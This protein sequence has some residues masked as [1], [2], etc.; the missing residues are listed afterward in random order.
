PPAEIQIELFLFFEVGGFANLS[1]MMDDERA[2][3]R[4]Q[5]QLCDDGLNQFVN[6]AHKANARIVAKQPEHKYFN[7]ITELAPFVIVFGVWNRTDVVGIPQVSALNQSDGR[8]LGDFC[9][10]PDQTDISFCK[11]F[12]RIE[13][14]NPV[15]AGLVY[16]MILGCAEVSGPGEV[17]HASS[18]A[19]GNLNSA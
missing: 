5:F 6:P 13:K 17:E 2:F 11:A 1:E 14:E 8:G 15:A 4:V 10:F 16:R 7:A 9:F 3:F 19:P 12:I 18:E